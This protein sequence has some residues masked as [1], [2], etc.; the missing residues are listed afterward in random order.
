MSFL[1]THEADMGTRLL[2]SP[3]MGVCPWVRPSGQ[4]MDK[5]SSHE[6]SLPPIL[7]PIPPVSRILSLI[8][9]MKDL[10]GHV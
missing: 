3:R 7:L 9:V 6:L 1:V 8:P 10:E 2:G 4:G 5:G